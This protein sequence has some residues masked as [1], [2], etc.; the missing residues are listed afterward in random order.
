MGELW[1]CAMSIVIYMDGNSVDID[2]D[3]NNEKKNTSATHE[4]APA[5]MQLHTIYNKDALRKRRK[6]KK[7][8][9]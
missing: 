9:R 7:K 4:Q 1:V 3:V 5:P 8:K 2:I 6:K